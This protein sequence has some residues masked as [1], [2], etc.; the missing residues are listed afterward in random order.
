[1]ELQAA[2]ATP[3]RGLES[4]LATSELQTRPSRAR[5]HE[6][7][8]RA[9]LSVAESM[10][11]AP[12]SILQSLAAAVLSS[13]RAGSAGVSLIEDDG[14]AFRWHAMAG[15]LAPHAGERTPRALSPCATVAESEEVQLFSHPARHFT[16]LSGV[17]PVI[18][19]ALLVPFSAE[20]GTAGAI[21]A[22]SH[23]EYRRFDKED[24]RLMRGL[25]RFAAA[26][27]QLRSAAALAERSGR[28]KDDFLAFLAHEM[29]TPLFAMQ[30][31][32][33]LIARRPGFVDEVIRGSGV[34][35]R[36]I[37]QLQRLVTD[38][39]DVARIHRG[40]LE[41]RLNRA[42]LWPIVQEAVEAS[43]PL[44]DARGH[45]LTLTP[46]AAALAVMADPARVVQIV[47]NLLNNAAKFTPLGGH[48]QVRLE[49]ERGHAV[50]SVVDDGTGMAEQALSTVFDPYVQILSAELRPGLGIGL[51]LARSLARLHGGT[52]EARS[53][54]LAKGSEFVVRLPLCEPA[55]PQESAARWIA[56]A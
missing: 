16:H 47:C 22:V 10:R 12:A 55:M 43:V 28:R 2:I 48:I 37:A 4:V 51:G 53:P 31:G 34:L 9:L 32:A 24:A 35:Q 39:L 33:E 30:L 6:A 1:M 8:N 38:L 17:K 50:L 42:E 20:S 23:D 15:E 46:P 44:I 29:Q 3:I 49:S 11:G 52:L 14:L 7:E 36:Q 41:L 54:G 21:W 27:Y 18:V 40:K 45:C 19:E 56:G 25:G 26:A 5:D 13:C